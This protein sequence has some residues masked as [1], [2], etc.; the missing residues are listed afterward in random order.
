[1]KLR[2]GIIGGMGPAAT[3][4]FFNK[5]I[6][7]T[8]VVKDSEHFRII[9]D[10]NPAIPDR[11]EAILGNGP[12]PVEQL[13]KT[14]N[15][16]QLMG[17]QLAAIPC[18]TAHYFY[19]DVI[20]QTDLKILNALEEIK[21]YVIEKFPS[22]TKLGILATS[23]TK[24]AGLF[25]KYFTNY[26]I[27][28]PNDL[29]QEEN[30]MRAIYDEKF[31]IKSGSLEGHSVNLLIS[32]GQHLISN[33]VE[34]IIYG[35]TEVPLVLDSRSFDVPSLDPMDVLAIKMVEYGKNFVNDDDFCYK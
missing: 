10:N 27:L 30:V 18:I 8:Q 11:T 1:M 16:L 35:C 6:Y 34:L 7:H 33:G 21:K 15:N 28:W 2:L 22:K 23:G 24:K 5:I 14:A 25:E 3:A 20:Q 13:V 32:A 29:I 19:D 12:S 17:V 26:T 9:I 4:H 31:G